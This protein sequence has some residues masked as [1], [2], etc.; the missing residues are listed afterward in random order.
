MFRHKYFGDIQDADSNK[1]PC[2]KIEANFIIVLFVLLL[3][4]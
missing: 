1:I 3:K 4:S 2:L